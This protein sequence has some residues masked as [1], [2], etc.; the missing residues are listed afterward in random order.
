MKTS[1]EIRETFLQYFEERG[2]KRVKSASLIPGNDPTLLFTNAGMNQFKDVFLGLEERDCRRAASSQKCMRVSGKHNDLETVGRTARHHTFFEMLGNFSFGDYFKKEAI[3]FAWELC[4]AVYG[5][6]ADRFRITVYKEDQEAFD[7]W[8]THIGVP[9]HWIYRL[10]EAENFWAMGATGPCGPCSELHFDLGSSPVGHTECTAEC[11]CGRYLE[12]WNLVFM[13]FSRDETGTMTPLPSPSIDT[14]MGLERI[15]CILQGVSS[16]YDTDLF[17][18]IIEEACRLLG[19]SYG[20]SEEKDVSLRILADH[21]RACAFLITDGVVPGNEGRGYVLRKI[22]RRA[23]RHGRML[24]REEPFLYTLTALVGELMKS[25]YP[26][27][28]EGRE[29]AAQVVLNEEEKFS[30]TL[31][32]GTRRLENVFEQTQD[33]GVVAGKDL[34]QLHDTYGFPLDLAREMAAERGF[35]VDESGFY[36]EME[37]QRERARASWK[38]TDRAVSPLYRQLAE[39]S[40]RTEF[41]GYDRIAAVEG[42]VLAILRHNRP[43]DQLEEGCK[44]ELVLSR[45]PFY[46]EAGGQVGDQGTIESE[47]ANARVEDTFTPL[48]GLRLHRVRVRSGWIR[49]GDRVRS[50]VFSEVR[51]DT[52]RNHTATHLLQAALREVL[53]EHVK[54]SGSLVAPDRLR[55]DFTHYRPMSQREVRQ[56]EER[57]NQ[58]VREN[59]QLQT[60]IR[61]L[62]EAVREGA[63]AL[64]GEKYQER[65]RVVRVPGFSMELCGGTHVS[66]TGEIALFKIVGEGSVSAGVR[67]IE[68]VT[69]QAA[70]ERF[71]SSEDVLERL[72]ETL[73]VGRSQLPEAVEKMNRALKEAGKELEGLQLRLAQKETS[74]VLEEAREI[75]GVRVLSRKVENLDRSSLRSLADQLKNKLKSGIVV[76]GMPAN[77]KVNL[78]AMVS[79]DLTE[80]IQANDLIRRLAPIVK[81]GG[82]GKADMAEAGGRDPS[83]LD[84]A[85]E[86]TYRLV[87]ES[88]GPSR[89]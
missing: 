25:A 29:Y 64:F 27:L 12:I 26:E 79:A 57:V 69:G 37:Q 30:A 48:P 20:Q 16:N 88:L 65:V 53:G 23:V 14:G 41:T 34:F 71:F 21:S 74:S 28:E 19:V 5:L 3:E 49:R 77:G 22:L 73:K 66:S 46:A 84:R 58:K 7:L 2:H 42:T 70:L 61:D 56:I 11:D 72:S 51:A 86:Q 76:L 82:G 9:E 36:Q 10:G 47:A 32:H 50:T 45:S 33:K 44:G 35:G 55:F 8:K 78:V 62:E 39:K 83:Q 38:G 6:P 80:R 60:E 31:T 85:L 68:A 15:A 13:Q 63:M 89:P 54:Q 18:P 59:I 43:V 75:K 81:G 17:V 4:T 1:S 87:A 24:G 52:A 67:R 40:L